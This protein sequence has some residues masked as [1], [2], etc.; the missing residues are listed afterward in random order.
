MQGV[1]IRRMERRGQVQGDLSCRMA[2]R[3]TACSRRRSSCTD[4]GAYRR[5][6]RWMGIRPEQWSCTRLLPVVG[7][8][9][10]RTIHQTVN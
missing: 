9:L 6:T 3:K 8:K 1:A 7:R 5:D 4:D 10:N 2:S